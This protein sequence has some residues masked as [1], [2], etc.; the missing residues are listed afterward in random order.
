M[1]SQTSQVLTDVRAFLQPLEISAQKCQMS[2]FQFCSLK[3][4]A[5]GCNTRFCLPFGL[6]PH[7]GLH[8]ERVVKPVV[9]ENGE[10]QMEHSS[11]LSDSTCVGSPSE[12]TGK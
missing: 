9:D 7:P 3:F 5:P 1:F 12:T 2:R 10:L 4:R 11:M 6:S 8:L